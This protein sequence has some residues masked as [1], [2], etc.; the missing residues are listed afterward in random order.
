MPAEWETHEATWIGWPHNLTDWPGKLD[1]I[2][3]VY[4]EIVRRIAP[5]ELVRILVNSASHEKR[6]RGILKLAG[7][8][9]TRVQFFRR[10]KPPDEL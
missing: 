4:G 3:W 5:G 1:P 10:S 8:P 6:V 2:L 9:M 7:V